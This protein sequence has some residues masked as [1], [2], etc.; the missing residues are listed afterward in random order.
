MTREIFPAKLPDGVKLVKDCTFWPE[1][2]W[3]FVHDGAVLLVWS[4]IVGWVDYSDAHRT[5]CHFQSAEA[6]MEAWKVSHHKAAEFKARS[7]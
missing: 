3:Y 1:G 5:G 4:R 6:A 7:N 2:S